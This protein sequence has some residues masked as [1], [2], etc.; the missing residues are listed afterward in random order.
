MEQYI[1]LEDI[2]KMGTMTTKLA[3]DLV[4]GDIVLLPFHHNTARRQRFELDIVVP[5]Q[6]VLLEVPVGLDSVF[7][8]SVPYNRTVAPWRSKA[9]T[10][11][12]RDTAYRVLIP[13]AQP[14][15]VSV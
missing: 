14:A 5:S 13:T 1:D 2:A 10:L 8:D 4:P 11:T 12:S 3:I 6:P 7:F 15:L 9:T